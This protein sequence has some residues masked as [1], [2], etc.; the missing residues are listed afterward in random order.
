MSARR[1]HRDLMAIVS[2]DEA[3]R[4]PVPGTEFATPKGARGVVLIERSAARKITARL[5]CTAEGC[6]E[7]HVREISDWH[8]CARC[9][10]HA[11][12]HR[13]SSSKKIAPAV[14]GNTVST[15]SHRV[16]DEAQLLQRLAT[17]KRP[18]DN[19]S[20]FDCYA[21]A[22][23]RGDKA[24]A[25]GVVLAIA[26]GAGQTEIVSGIS[27]R[28]ALARFL[29][30][31]LEAATR[32]KIHVLFGQDHQYGIPVALLPELDGAAGA[33]RTAMRRV[34]VEGPLGKHAV[35]GDAGAFGAAANQWLSDKNLPKYF[36]SATKAAKY[37]VPRQN[38]RPATGVCQHRLTE[39]RGKVLFNFSRLGDNGA[40]GGQT[41]VGIPHVLALLDGSAAAGVQVRVWPFDALRLADLD[42]CHLA[43]EVYPSRVRC[44]GVAQSDIHDAIACTA[45]AQH[46]DRSATLARELDLSGL[47]AVD[48]ARVKLEGWI[49]GIPAH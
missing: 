14:I 8:Q 3:K 4:R 12:Q 46:K 38:P 13:A 36:W 35:A 34:F 37:G 40:V 44:A 20:H 23:Y 16:T 18:T 45:W 48:Q 10:S 5:T 7:T 29:P 21:F 32:A 27:T 28:R 1:V 15:P 26:L 41:I 47:S 22:D 42:E 25:G 33:W 43:I 9:R 39:I 49:A 31:L 11:T 2:M 24:D 30:R 6:D 17:Y 19:S